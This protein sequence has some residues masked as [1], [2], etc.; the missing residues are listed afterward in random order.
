MLRS[1]NKKLLDP[2]MIDFMNKQQAH[3]QFFSS[4]ISFLPSE[5][6]FLSLHDAVIKV[7][8]LLSNVLRGLLDYYGKFLKLSS[9]PETN[10]WLFCC[11]PR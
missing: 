8:G 6:I 2:K 5:G 11:I 4:S 10:I 3:S 1:L 9:L 7:A